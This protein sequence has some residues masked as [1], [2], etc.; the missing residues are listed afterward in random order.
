MLWF[1]E[2]GVAEEFL[3]GRERLVVDKLFRGGVDVGTM[4]DRSSA[5][6][7]RTLAANPFLGIDDLDPGGELLGTEAERRHYADTFARTGYRGG[8]NW[9]RN[10]DAN[11]ARHPEIGTARIDV[12]TLML[13]AELDPALPPSLAAGMGE[14]CGDLETHVIE[15]AGHWVQQERPDE[16]NRLLVDWLVR[17]F[18]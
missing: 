17:R 13:C 2:E 6:E 12:P 18:A 14:L 11:A 8:I 3:R 10:I 9:Y 16:V 4:F 15:G 1:Q 7:P 5:A